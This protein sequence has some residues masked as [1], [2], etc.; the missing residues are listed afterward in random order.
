MKTARAIGMAVLMVVVCSLMAACSSDD[1][2]DENGKGSKGKHEYVDLGLPSGTLWATCNIGSS[3]PEEYGDYFAWGEIE[4]Y[5][6]GKTYF[7][8]STHKWCNGSYNS[9]TKYNT[10]NSLGTVDNK[11]ELDLDDDAAYV[12]W[13][14]AWRMP[15]LEQFKE[16]INSKYTTTT[17]TTLNGVYGRKITSKKNGNSIFLPAAGGRSNSSYSAGSGGCYWSCS[18]YAGGPTD[19]QGIYFNSG[20][21]YAD[22]SERCSG[23][24]VRPVR[25]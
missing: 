22:D 11:T 24:S 23:R 14:A 1:D 8:W 13:G 3:S 10:K 15:S 25:R 7:S 12:N 21:I 9:L 20:E 4:G 5:H 18:L 19:A 17:W 16:L 2:E 6:S